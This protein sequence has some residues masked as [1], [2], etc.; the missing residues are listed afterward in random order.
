[1]IVPLALRVSACRALDGATIAGAAVHDS[2][3]TAL[4]EMVSGQ[5]QPFIVVSVDEQ[6]YN[7]TVLDV[8]QGSRSVDLVIDIAVGS[9]V[10]LEDGTTG[11]VI[12][13]TDAGTEFSVNLITR[14]VMKTLFEPNSGGDWGKIFRRI[15]MSVSRIMVRRGAGA[16]KG[17]KFAAAQLIISLSPLADPEF[18]SAP[19]FVWA[20]FLTVMRA[21]V[22][23][24]PLAEA[25]EKAIVGDVLPDWRLLASAVGLNDE[26][27]DAIGILPLGGGDSQPVSQA[28][29]LPDGWVLDQNAVDENLPGAPE[30]GG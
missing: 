29:V 18:G 7:V 30:E 2:A 6:T 17:V 13:H 11:I 8:F 22:K 24:G 1:L 3:I 14:Q 27:A 9:A 23:I 25:V 26:T 15:A 5:P 16:Q 4:D 21:D 20:D 28:I 10:T 12:P 19:A